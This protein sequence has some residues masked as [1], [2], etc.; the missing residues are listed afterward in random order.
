MR[1]GCYEVRLEQG[2]TVWASTQ[3]QADLRE[4]L[5]SWQGGLG[6]MDEGKD[7]DSW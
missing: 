4:Q 1:E 5:D 3:E 7:Q 2:E 6:P